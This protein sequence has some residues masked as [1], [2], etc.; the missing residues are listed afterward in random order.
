MTWQPEALD[1]IYLQVHVAIVDIISDGE[2]HDRQ[3]I[4]ET[5]ATLTGAPDKTIV[6]GLD[7]CVHFGLL[8]R[9]RRGRTKVTYRLRPALPRG[10][11]MK[12]DERAEQKTR[13]LIRR[14]ET[15]NLPAMRDRLIAAINRAERITNEHDGYPHTTTGSDSPGGNNELTSVEAA[16]NARLR[17]SR[18]TDH[19]LAAFVALDRAV[20]DLDTV[21]SQLKH[22][23]KLVDPD[24]TQKTKR[25]WA[26]ARHGIDTVPDHYCDPGGNL[27]QKIDVCHGCYQYILRTGELPPRAVLVARQQ[28]QAS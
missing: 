9:T 19:V 22:A 11:T 7:S 13:D 17:D 23:E 21:D 15:A 26:C 5:V 6:N 1:G 20:G 18:Y 3:Q 4:I 14:L 16:A 25:C 2:W 10:P 27:G 12:L 28:Q 8:S 24:H